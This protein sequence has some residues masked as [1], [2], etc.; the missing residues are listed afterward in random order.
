MICIASVARRSSR[1][2]IARRT[3]LR[4]F[5]LSGA[6]DATDKLNITAQ[7]YRRDSDRDGLNGDIYEGFR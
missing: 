3:R 2:P 4:Q 1:P 7:V 6:W 5:A